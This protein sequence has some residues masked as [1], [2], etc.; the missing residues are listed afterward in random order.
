MKKSWLKKALVTVSCLS[1]AGG[2]FGVYGSVSA[3]DPASVFDED[4]IEREL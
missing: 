1:L 3:S 2:I 4:A